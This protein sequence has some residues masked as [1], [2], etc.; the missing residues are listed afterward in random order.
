MDTKEINFYEYKVGN[1]SA[2]GG[3]ITTIFAVHRNYILYEVGNCGMISTEIKQASSFHEIDPYVS[4]IRSLCK[5]RK[6]HLKASRNIAFAMTYCLDDNYKSAIDY[7]SKAKE[8]LINERIIQNKLFYLITCI[9]F[10]SG[11]ITVALLLNRFFPDEKITFLSKIA[12]FGS[13]GG[14]LSIS[15]QIKK[16]QIDAYE[17]HLV[18]IC[19]GFTRVFIAMISSLIVFAIIKSN[20]IM[21]F[22]ND[23]DNSYVFYALA[24]VSGFSEYFVPNILK[25]IEQNKINNY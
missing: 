12:T 1:E 18:Q 21:D 11:N 2:L 7:I 24:C 3:K 17:N 6:Q 8:L 16:L 20:L 25:T 22:L 10:I 19:T 4:E 15:F 5:S 23:S 13:F 9:V 14:F